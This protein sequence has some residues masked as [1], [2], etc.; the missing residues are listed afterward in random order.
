MTLSSFVKRIL[1]RFKLYEHSLC[2]EAVLGLKV[3]LG[4]SK[5]VVV[6]VVPRI[7]NLASLLGCKGLRCL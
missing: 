5:M 4:K 2:F 3:N 6:G 1:A 7:N